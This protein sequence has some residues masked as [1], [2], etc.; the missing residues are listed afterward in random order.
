MRRA[1]AFAL[2]SLAILAGAVCAQVPSGGYG[3]PS[4]V[5]AFPG[6]ISGANNFSVVGTPNCQTA[7]QSATCTTAAFTVSANTALIGMA[8]SC[9]NNNCSTANNQANTITDASGSNVW[10]CPA[11][12]TKT[13]GNYSIA[14]C[15]VCNAV[16]G[17]YTITANAASTSF[18][19]EAMVAAV[20]GVSSASC[21]DTPTANAVFSANSANPAISLGGAPLQSNEFIFGGANTGNSPVPNQIN[22]LTAFAN[23]IQYTLGPAVGGTTQLSWTAPAVKNATAILGF[24][25]P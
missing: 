4:W 9:A 1:L 16:A 17:T 7:T 19:V 22:I 5:G 10:T 24:F 15:Y 25:H 21:A 8:L 13:G 12:A 14:I 23:N 11:G 20:K 6:P 18:F 3:S 2:L